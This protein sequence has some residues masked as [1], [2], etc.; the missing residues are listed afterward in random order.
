MCIF[1]RV[2]ERARARVRVRAR[3]R[4]CVRVRVHARVRVRARARVRVCV[5][6]CCIWDGSLLVTPH[7]TAAIYLYSIHPHPTIS[8]PNLNTLFFDTPLTFLF[9]FLRSS[10]LLKNHC[11]EIGRLPSLLQKPSF[12]QRQARLKA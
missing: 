8:R 11:T 12:L 5:C 6:V 4:V 10:F 1:V 3:A 7:L 2:R 9:P